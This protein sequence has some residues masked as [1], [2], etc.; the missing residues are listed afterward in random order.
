MLFLAAGSAMI[1]MYAQRAAG[2]VSAAPFALGVRLKNAIFSYAAYLEKA[3]WPTQLAPLYPHPG[4]S[5]AIWKV[6]LAAAFLISSSLLVI[7]FRTRRYLVTGLLWFLGTLVPVIG[8][9]QVGNQAMADRYAYIPL[10]GIFLMVTWGVGG[11]VQSRK[12]AV[13]WA[14]VPAICVLAALSVVS[15][16]QIG[17]WQNGIDLWT[18]TLQVTERNF[19][20]EDSLGAALVE[21]QRFDEA[22][23][24]FLKAAQYEPNDPAARLNIGA[25]LHQHGH[26]TEAI[27][28]YK[29]ALALGTDRKLRATTYENL[30]TAY[31]QLGEDA[32]ARGA[33]EQTLRLN[34]NQPKAWL[35]LGMLAEKQGNVGEEI[36]D[37]SISVQLQPTAESCLRLGRVLAQTGHVSEALN[38][39]AE[40]LQIS[41][42][43]IEAQQ[44]I[45]ALRQRKTF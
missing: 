10:I 26:V 43:L 37:F 34:P 25:Y 32:E 13:M 29:V 23:S 4:N 33:L 35:G 30:G 18:H 16:R 38:A 31:Q 1:T 40:A 17:Y 45:E 28:Q 12:I 44:A 5:L 41:P 7:K 42:D 39:Y 8:L 36:K 21:Q 22:Y 27:Q 9:V 20:A 6:S 15:Y 3:V 2:A 11:L 19:V 14:A 24:H